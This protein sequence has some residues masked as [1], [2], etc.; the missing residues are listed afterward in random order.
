MRDGHWAKGVGN[1]ERPSKAKLLQRYSDS[2]HQG[3]RSGSL[4][5]AAR[6]EIPVVAGTAPTQQTTRNK[7]RGSPQSKLDKQDSWEAEHDQKQGQLQHKAGMLPEIVQDPRAESVWIGGLKGLRHLQENSP[8][9][10]E[11]NRRG[12]DPVT[13]D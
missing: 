12:G 6:H 1:G 9:C 3:D 7:G 5:R 8:G 10:T 11:P 13:N 4:N 2:P